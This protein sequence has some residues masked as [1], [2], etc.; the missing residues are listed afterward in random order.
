MNAQNVGISATGTP[1]DPAAM[2][3]VD[4]TTGLSSGNQKGVLIPTVAL[5]NASVAA[6]IGPTPLPQSLVVFNT[7]ASMA[8]GNGPGFYYWNGSKWVYLAAP[9]N[10]P[11]SPGQVLTSQGP[12]NP[13]QWSTLS[14]G[15][16][17]YGYSAL[18]T[19]MMT[20][21]MD[22]IGLFRPHGNN[23]SASE[24][25]VPLWSGASVGYCIEKTERA[26]AYWT[27]AIRTCLSVGKRLPEPWEWQVACD[28][29]ATLGLSNMTNNWEWASNFALPMSDGSFYGAGAAVFGNGGCNRAD[30]GWLGTNTGYRASLAFRCVH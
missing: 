19:A 6:P 23:C 18:G 1:P 30:W 2:L 21:Y 3:H 28:N 5:T 7:N 11:G 22:S 14:V 17:G 4:G 24:A 29:A 15:G 16:G 26:G 10:G 13:P 25:F 9:A 27:D 12:N 8:N 20:A